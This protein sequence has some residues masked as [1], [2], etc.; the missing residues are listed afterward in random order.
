MT[1]DIIVDNSE[2]AMDTYNPTSHDSS[3]LYSS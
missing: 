1:K 3:N 2:L